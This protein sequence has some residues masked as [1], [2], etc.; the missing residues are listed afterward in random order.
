MSETKFGPGKAYGS[1]DSIL[2][3]EAEFGEWQP[4]ATAPKDFTP[5]LT[6]GAEGWIQIA[7][8]HCDDGNPGEEGWWSEGE[9]VLEPTHWMPLPEPPK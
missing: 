3:D 4:I 6:A 5:I 1:P 9:A 8:W 7:R 2:V